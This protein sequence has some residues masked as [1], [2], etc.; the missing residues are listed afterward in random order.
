MSNSKDQNQ[1]ANSDSAW[2]DPRITSYVLGE[3]SEDD[4]REFESELK[5]NDPLRSA[6]DQAESITSQLEGLFAAEQTPALEDARRDKIVSQASTAQ[7]SEFTNAATGPV[8]KDTS[9]LKFGAPSWGTPLMVMATAAVLL[10]LVGIAPFLRQR[11]TLTALD[12]A[13]Q[14]DSPIS[15][16][17]QPS[18]PSGDES[19]TPMPAGAES[20]SVASDKSN[21]DT[22]EEAEQLPSEQTA[23][24]LMLDGPAFDAED[25]IAMQPS[26]PKGMSLKAMRAK[27]RD[28]KKEASKETNVG[29]GEVSLDDAGSKRTEIPMGLPPLDSLGEDRSESFGLNRSN[30]PSDSDADADPIAAAQARIMQDLGPIESI[31]EDAP[32]EP[33]LQFIPDLSK[34]VIKGAKKEVEQSDIDGIGNRAVGKPKMSAASA[35]PAPAAATPAPVTPG[36]IA[37]SIEPS[38]PMRMKRQLERSDSLPKTISLG[39]E[40]RE[41]D[42]QMIGGRGRAAVGNKVALNVRK[43]VAE[44]GAGGKPFADKSR[45]PDDGRG[46]GNAGDQFEPI[47]DNDF[48]RVTE[49]PLSTFSADV[50]T[51]S[52]S[53]VRDY[54][55]R[56]RSLPRP[57]AVRIEELVNYFDYN[58]EPPTKDSEH[59]FVAHMDITGCPWTPEH[60]LARIAIK[61]KEINRSERPACN[62]VFLLDTSGSMDQPNKLPLVLEGMKML[63]DQLTEKDK[64]AIAVYSGSAGT[65]LDSTPAN[66]TKKIRRALSELSAGGSTAGGEGI[67]LAYQL[68]RDEFIADGV[69]RVILCT[70]GDFNVGVTGT[71]AL[72]RMVEQESKGGIFLSVLGFGMGNHNDA[73]LEQ[74]S[75]RGNGNYAFIDTQA[76]AKKVLVRQ[77]NGTL[78]TI[79]KDVKLQLEFNPKRVAQYRLIGYENRL[80][81][82]EDFNDD[83]KDAGEIGAGHTVTALYE[84]V[85]SGIE[86]VLSKP[87]VDE[88]KYQ[89]AGVL[90]ESAE[91]LTLKIRYKLPDEDTST[92]VDFVVQDDDGEFASADA[93][94]RFAAAVAGF[95]MKLRR[96]KYAGAWTLNDVLRVAKESTG[97]D[98]YQLR[99]EFLEI[100]TKASE[101][102]GQQ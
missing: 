98:K 60:R 55:M 47:E 97:D 30:T 72:V 19:R 73:M 49:E 34:I 54:I 76:E 99:Q 3:L 92:K 91:L 62:L 40:V 80:L 82:K 16:I 22:D 58:Y 7:D 25:S 50:D 43:K 70:D 102:M 68:A 35:K 79:A 28:Q 56:T 14:V 15:P 46:P 87:K 88:L 81:A 6:V 31:S 61:G 37:E 66:K 69:N 26:S 11:A 90:N 53:K 86:P 63:V 101:L 74:I 45:R 41:A 67:A 59:P 78:V 10:L 42:D 77:T 93:D 2:E 29:A 12:P 36:Q 65:V 27:L 48:V 9:D 20:E 57:D 84:I 38:Q 8:T 17:P 4:R 21:A 100:V 33:D 64:V 75:G 5:S 1:S 13:H 94:V 96:S 39:K 83:Q 52:Y 89:K 71:D 51:A 18:A 32:A 44:R 23:A 95:G 85:P 24:Q